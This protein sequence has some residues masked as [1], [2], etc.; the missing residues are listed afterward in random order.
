VAIRVSWRK[1]KQKD[2]EVILYGRFKI[3]FRTA[4]GK[5]GHRYTERSTLTGEKLKARQY[6]EAEY[7]KAYEEA[8]KP[9]EGEVESDTFAAAA[10]SY[11]KNK[12]SKKSPVDGLIPASRLKVRANKRYLYPVIERIGTK[13]LSEIDQATVDN[14]STE[15]YAGCTAAT[16]NRQ[17]HTPI[18][19]VMTF[20]G[21]AHDIKRPEGHDNL[22]EI[23]VPAN[24]WYPAVLRA[25]NPYARAFTIVVRLT[26]RRP[27]ELL[28]RTR[29]HFNDELGTLTIW[30]GKG[31]QYIVL[32][33]PE[34]A[35]VAI[36]ALPDLSDAKKGSTRKG[37]KLT[38]AKRHHLFGTNQK[39]TMRK[40]MLDACKDAGVPYHTAYEAGRHAFVTKNLEEG[41]SLKWVMEAG[42]WKRIKVPAE[43]YGHY[44]RQEVDRQARQSGE[45]WFRKVLSQPVEI[46]AEPI[47]D[48][49][50]IGG[51]FGDGTK[52]S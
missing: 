21:H 8:H 12:G 19:A 48:Q 22:P 45:D 11:M 16:I 3:P 28:N 2:G 47:Q 27:D 33:L 9:R 4:E 15:L 13:K 39:S 37:E 41:K 20:V 35:L 23:K 29:E 7:Q 30:D 44:E 51:R 10:I 32:T 17:L 46:D 43:R 38:H 6:V 1:H 26:G 18:I 24:E 49:R 36:R 5:I 25:A 14:L 40:W 52:S 31:K 42:R 34:P 50:L